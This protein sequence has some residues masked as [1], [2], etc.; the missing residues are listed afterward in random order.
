MAYERDPHGLAVRLLGK[1]RK[2][3]ERL[4][5]LLPSVDVDLLNTRAADWYAILIADP[6]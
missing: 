4:Q 6:N 2:K 1:C 5:G 3:G